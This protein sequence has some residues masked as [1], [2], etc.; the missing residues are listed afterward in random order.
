MEQLNSMLLNNEQ[1][2]IT[3]RKPALLSVLDKVLHLVL[4]LRKP[5]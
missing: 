4:V 3:G 2:Q 1:W 5:K